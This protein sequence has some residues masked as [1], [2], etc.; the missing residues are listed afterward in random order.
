MMKKLLLLSAM[1]IGCA[2]SEVLDFDAFGTSVDAGVDS[3]SQIVAVITCPLNIDCSNATVQTCPNDKY[4][5]ACAGV[6]LIQHSGQ[7]STCQTGPTPIADT[8]FCSTP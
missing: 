2:Q 5:F 7:A 6:N 1:A 4:V 3:G 8:V